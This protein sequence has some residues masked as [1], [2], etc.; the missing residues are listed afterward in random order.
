MEFTQEQ[1]L[2]VQ[3]EQLATWKTKL[4]PACYL[5]LRTWAMKQNAELL[6]HHTGHHVARGSSLDEFVLNWQG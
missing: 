2:E 5:D 6:P 1:G 3:A 4:I